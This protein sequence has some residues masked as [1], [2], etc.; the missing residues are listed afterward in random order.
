MTEPTHDDV[1][2]S[3]GPALL[4]GLR[5]LE[6]TILAPAELGGILADL[7]ADVIKIEPPEG[8]YG[9]RMTWPM[10][11][12]EDGSE[13]SLLS[14]HVNRGKR[15]VVLNLQHPDGVSAYLDLARHSDVV[16]EGM[17]PGALARRGI[18]LER[19]WEANPALVF[20]SISGY[21]ASGPYR[22]LPSHG[23][24]YD[25]WAG[26]VRVE[27]DPQGFS[28]IADHTSIGIHAGPAY[29]ALGILSG[30]LSARATGKGCSIEIAQS[31]ASVYFDWWAV[32]AWRSYER[33]LEEVR[34][35]PADDGERRPPGPSGMRESVRYQIYAT[36]DGFVLLMASEQSFWKNFCEAIGRPDL[37]QRW[38][39]VR[40]GDHARGNTELRQ[41][42]TDTF[43]T[44]T[45]AD[46]LA[47]GL[48]HD[49][50]LA[51]VNTSSSVTADPQFL[52]RF[53]W[54]PRTRFGAD[55][56]PFPLRVGGSPLPSHTH[57]PEV[58]QDSEEVL[59][60]VVGYTAEE[61]AA[62]RSAGVLG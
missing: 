62:L 16:I 52:D 57:A 61:I 23:I 58:G 10:V 12:L 14:L 55:M 49:V 9:R 18:T 51:P 19:L 2:D 8:D 59:A 40:Y 24:A 48:E 41:I 26:H 36:Q 56:L 25:S 7:G 44:R 45:S 37:F 28:Y 29:A 1:V 22:D 11:R 15:S 32:E 39:G 46:W 31:D 13:T 6:S 50:P 4:G 30:V 54:Q 38:P 43:V 21:G 3:R 53:S 20:C 47:M 35:S 60:E 5:V 27:H 34:G 17:R 33:P 42:L